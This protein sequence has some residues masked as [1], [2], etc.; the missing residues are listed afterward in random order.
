[1]I[2]TPEK[3]RLVYAVSELGSTEQIVAAVT[4]PS[5]GL[6]DLEAMLKRLLLAVPAQAPPPRS[7]PTNIEAML[8]RLRPG[9]PTPAPQPHPAT[10]PTILCF[11]CGKYGHRVSICPQL[12][13]N[14]LPGWSAEKMGDHYVMISPRLAAE[15]LRAGNGD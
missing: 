10:A 8:K 14:R 2:P 1:M 6:A 11:S 5:V 9:T 13:V 15:R 12:D 3:A 4:G 7:P